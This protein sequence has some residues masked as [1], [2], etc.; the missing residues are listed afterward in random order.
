MFEAS[1][2]D[3]ESSRSPLASYRV[4]LYFKTTTIKETNSGMDYNMNASHKQHNK[5]KAI[6]TVELCPLNQRNSSS[7][8]TVQ[9]SEEAGGGGVLAQRGTQRPLLM[10]MSSILSLV[11]VTCL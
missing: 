3:I 1:L 11:V 10:E 4:R 5:Q 9:S 7:Q 8:W 6:H 2:G